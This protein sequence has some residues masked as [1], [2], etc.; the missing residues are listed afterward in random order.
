MAENS[1]EFEVSEHCLAHSHC[2]AVVAAYNR[3][4]LLEKRMVVMQQWCDFVESCLTSKSG[5]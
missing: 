4:T 3:T 1:V 2:D 5:A